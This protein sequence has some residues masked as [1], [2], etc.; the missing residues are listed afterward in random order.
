[1]ILIAYAKPAA[2]ANQQAQEPKG[3]KGRAAAW[4]LEKTQE[5]ET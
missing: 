2:I 5:A 4:Q 1:M 3:K